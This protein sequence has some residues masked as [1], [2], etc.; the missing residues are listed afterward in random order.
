MA[1]SLK[2][3]K[4]ARALNRDFYGF[5]RSPSCLFPGSP[6]FNI[7]VV[8]SVVLYPSRWLVAQMYEYLVSGQ[9]SL[10]QVDLSETR[11]ALPWAH[12]F[13]KHLLGNF[14]S[15]ISYQLVSDI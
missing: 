6:E 15:A 5:F 9:R 8:L 4:W 2:S 10:D 11:S 12:L 1:H 3:G 14:F 13:E 7:G